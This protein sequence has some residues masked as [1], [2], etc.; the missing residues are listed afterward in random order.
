MK[1]GLV[2][3]YD[4]GR[5]G[6]VQN[7]VFELAG[8]L[9]EAGHEAQIVGPGDSGPDGAVLVGPT[10]QLPA[11]GAATP[12]RLDPRVVRRVK[13][14]VDDCDVVHVHEPLMPSVSLGA[15]LR[16]SPP[17]VATFHADPPAAVSR[18]YRVGGRLIR[19]VLRR[20]Q[21]LTAVSPVAARALP[22]VSPRIIPNGIDV[23]AY[24]ELE[25]VARRV[26]FV[27]RDDPR[28]GLRVLLAAW[29]QVCAA[30][31]DASLHVVG[32]DRID[33][34]SAGV[35]FHGRVSDE[36]KRR[37]LSSSEV[38]CA[39]NTGGESFGIVIAEGMA[40][41]C[42]VVASAIPGF[43]F[44]AGDAAALVRPG[45]AAALAAGLIDLC[46]DDERRRRLA[47][48]G[49]ERVRRFDRSAVTA[50]YIAAYEDAIRAASC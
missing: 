30:V 21:I 27:G 28:K 26:V 38:F 16:A 9:R 47:A 41:G 11:N 48:A 39:P 45:D 3:P 4:L 40:A 33:D 2:C 17:I 35:V 6:G 20:A 24:P 49:A 7:Q 1:V 18:L 5:F 8:W 25:R 22:N 10:W 43:V 23:S 19:R 44:A 31:P 42:A 15:T 12:I 32:A 29:P 14:V 34:A 37:A 36:E 50:A 46:T 13:D